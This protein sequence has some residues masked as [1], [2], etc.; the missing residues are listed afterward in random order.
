MKRTDPAT[1]RLTAKIEGRVQG[2]GFRY[3]TVEEA[4]ALRL[5]G[6]VS[7]QADGTVAVVAEGPRSPLEALLAWLHHGPP[8]ARVG[9]VRHHFAEAAGGYRRF[10]VE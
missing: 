1:E 5:V 9:H 2:V 10:S 4:Q 7:N 3:A 8:G 6:A